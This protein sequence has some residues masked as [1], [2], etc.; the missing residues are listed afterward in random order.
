M[1][2]SEF[3]IRLNDVL[4]QRELP[5]YDELLVGHA[6]TCRDCQ[7]RL[8]AQ[9][10]LFAGLELFDPPALSPRFAQRVLHDARAPQIAVASHHAE[11]SS[12]NWP[13]IATLLAWAAAVLLALTVGFRMSEWGNPSPDAT[14][15]S[16]LPGT[17]QQLSP[18]RFLEYREL[19]HLWALQLPDAVE[20]LES[21]E[22][23][24][25]GIRPVRASFVVAIDTLYR[26]IPGSREPHSGVPQA[27]LMVVLDVFA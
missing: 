19:F 22:Q 4:D 26:T 20:Q 3:E 24:A 21:V 13:A 27:T 7:Q 16:A 17:S 8:A 11:R 6:Q 9:E 12:W 23:Y 2:C 14:L 25:P 10:A 1:N 15:A 5:Q 18:E